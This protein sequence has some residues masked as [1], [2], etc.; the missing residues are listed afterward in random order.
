MAKM[1]IRNFDF[2]SSMCDYL[3]TT[4]A[5]TYGKILHVI[6]VCMDQN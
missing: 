4:D 6:N 5:A 1:E 3:N 2:R